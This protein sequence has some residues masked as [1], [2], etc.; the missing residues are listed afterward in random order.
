M[1]QFVQLS[2]RSD[3]AAL[4]EI[5]PRT[6]VMT[7]DQMFNYVNYNDQRIIISPFNSVDYFRKLQTGY[8]QSIHPL[9]NQRQDTV[10]SF[11]SMNFQLSLKSTNRSLGFTSAHCQEF[12]QHNNL[13]FLL[14]NTAK[15]IK[16]VTE[17]FLWG[18][19]HRVA[20]DRKTNW[21]R[22]PLRFLLF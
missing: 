1:S 22:I 4:K 13:L 11:M 16:S 2:L 10:Q 7:S 15:T 3:G 9:Q 5:R 14:F 6:A 20:S 19:L 12:L 18:K 8:M 17:S 21:K